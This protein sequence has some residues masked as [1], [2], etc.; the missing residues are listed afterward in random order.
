LGWFHINRIVLFST[1][2]ACSSIPCEQLDH[3]KRNL[4][5]ALNVF[6]DESFA[7]AVSDSDAA[8][9]N[10]DE[11][12]VQEVD[13]DLEDEYDEDILE[14]EIDDT[15]AHI[16]EFIQNY[17]IVPP[18]PLPL[19]VD[20]SIELDSPNGTT[21]ES[22]NGLLILGELSS[23]VD[24]EPKKQGK[25]KDDFTGQ[26]EI[27]SLDPKD[28]ESNSIPEI[29]TLSSNIL[30]ANDLQ[31]TNRLS[32]A[33]LEQL[34]STLTSTFTEM[35]QFANEIKDKIANEIQQQLAAAVATTAKNVSGEVMIDSSQGKISIILQN[36]TVLN[37]LLLMS[38]FVP[39]LA[40]PP[41]GL[42]EPI[43]LPESI[44]ENVNKKIAKYKRLAAKKQQ[45]I[46]RH[47]SPE[48]RALLKISKELS[49]SPSPASS[50][51]DLSREDLSVPATSDTNNEE[52]ISASSSASESAKPTTLPSY[53]DA[54]IEITGSEVVDEIQS[55]S[56]D[57]SGKQIPSDYQ[58]ISLERDEEEYDSGSDS[59]SYEDEEVDEEELEGESEAEESEEDVGSSEEVEQLS[60]NDEESKG[61]DYEEVEISHSSDY[62]LY[63]NK[64]TDKMVINSAEANISFATP[65][66]DIIFDDVSSP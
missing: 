14:I 41:E 28:N 25:T 34:L 15:E 55:E 46:S 23:S 33:E 24:A 53:V 37:R 2:Q 43:T 11:K 44:S 16:S 20:R 13:E 66:A 42:Y 40:E 50:R 9:I 18:K 29:G 4:N 39:T 22:S 58:V 61:I 32:S 10:R 59:V 36:F 1:A 49:S 56:E 7:D 12:L 3:I 62:D 19:T 52:A 48:N 47:K 57:S 17:E 51:A 27:R 6:P 8:S 63:S 31:N 38:Y 65:T 54:E 21:K 45:K 64:D 5:D 26:E 30:S 60:R 35:G